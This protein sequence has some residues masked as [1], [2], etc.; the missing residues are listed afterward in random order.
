MTRVMVKNKKWTDQ[1][2]KKTKKN[3]D[4]QTRICDML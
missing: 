1:K 4:F 2:A 3:T